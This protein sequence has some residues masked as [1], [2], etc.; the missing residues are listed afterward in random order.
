MF[1][2]A[3]EFYGATADEAYC[4]GDMYAMT[5]E[6]CN[7]VCQNVLPMDIQDDCDAICET[8]YFPGSVIVNTTLTLRND[9]G[10]KPYVKCVLYECLASS[11]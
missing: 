3:F 9:T 6:T 5:N 11:H 4:F 10:A 7:L 1:S 2:S 8:S